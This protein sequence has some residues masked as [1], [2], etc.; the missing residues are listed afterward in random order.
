MTK[1]ARHRG[2]RN[3]TTV[4]ANGRGVGRIRSPCESKIKGGGIRGSPCLSARIRW[5]TQ[6]WR[7]IPPPC[8]GRVVR[9]SRACG[10]R[11]TG[12]GSVVATEQATRA[13]RAGC[14]PSACRGTR[15]ARLRR[16]RTQLEISARWLHPAPAER[17]SPK[18]PVRFRPCQHQLAETLL[19]LPAHHLTD[20]VKILAAVSVTSAQPIRL[21]VLPPRSA[22]VRG[23]SSINSAVPSVQ[24]HPTGPARPAR[25]P[26][27]QA[28]DQCVG[29]TVHG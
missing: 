19:T 2:T 20:L 12:N 27:M 4:A 16:P 14:V 26:G 24:R 8:G 18:G 15:R 25:R 11:C 9:S 28:Y 17:A 23:A 29:E 6:G 5:S 10:R 13:R 21:I 7:S 3:V 22:F 1:S